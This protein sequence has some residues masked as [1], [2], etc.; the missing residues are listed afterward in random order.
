MVRRWIGA[1]GARPS[2]CRTPPRRRG[3]AGTTTPDRSV[4]KT[5]PRGAP[6]ITSAPPGTTP[7]RA[8]D[9]AA[10]PVHQP[11]HPAPPSCHQSRL[12][13]RP[14]GHHH[15]RSNDRE[16]PL[17][18]GVAPCL[19]NGARGTTCPAQS[20]GPA[21]RGRTGRLC[22]ATRHR[23]GRTGLCTQAASRLRQ[24]PGPPLTLR[25]RDIRAAR[26]RA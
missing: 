2:R 14:G 10:T 5:D 19:H 17:E 12:A 6:R 13:R 23:G 4:H 11:C 25:P 16:A 1:G 26:E 9:Q 20:I 18:Q 3:R 24:G 21:T 7:G 22:D 15:T 8:R